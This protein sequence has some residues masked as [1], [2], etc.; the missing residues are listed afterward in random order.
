[1]RK[2]EARGSLEH[3]AAGRALAPVLAG[4]ARCRHGRGHGRRHRAGEVPVGDDRRRRGG[5]PPERGP[6]V[7]GQEVRHQKTEDGEEEDEPLELHEPKARRERDQEV[8][9]PHGTATARYR[10]CRVAAATT[11]RIPHEKWASTEETRSRVPRA[12]S[13]A[14][15]PNEPAGRPP[16]PAPTT[17][18][19]PG[20]LRSP[21][22]NPFSQNAS[23]A[24]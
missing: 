12:T 13:V 4:G 8:H 19:N 15:W 24:P 7:L 14:T 21:R 18:S 6:F 2:E 16:P 1:M 5:A 23:A 3:R 22:R 17:T 9:Q 11:T 10:T 20:R